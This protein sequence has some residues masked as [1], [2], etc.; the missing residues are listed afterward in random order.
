MELEQKEVELRSILE[1]IDRAILRAEYTPEG[2]L[3]FAN[4]LHRKTFGYN[5][6][7]VLGKSIFIFIPEE[8]QEEFKKLWAD[9]VAGNMRQLRVRRFTVTG[10]EVWLLNQYTPVIDPETGKVTKVLYLAQDI[11]EQVKA[12]LEAKKAL[13]IAKRHERHLLSFQEVLKKAEAERRAIL[14]GIDRAI[15]RAEYTPEGILTFANELHRKTFGYN[16]EEVL[17]KSIFIFIP[18]EEQEEFKKLW[19]DVVAGNMRQLR[20]RRF[21]AT[22]KEIWL[23]NQYTPVRDE[24]GN[25]YKILY[26]AQDITEQVRAEQE[27]KKALVEALRREKELIKLQREMEAAQKKMSGILR[28][29]DNMLYRIIYNRDGYIVDI[30]DNITK[31]FGE[32]EKIINKHYREICAPEDLEH[33]EQSFNKVLNGEIVK[34]ERQL[35]LGNRTV[36]FL[37]QFAPIYLEDQINEII[38]LNI[39]ITEQKMKEQQVNKL[40]QEALQRERDLQSLLKAVDSTMLRADYTP[41]GNLLD[42]NERH[43]QTMGY[44][45]NQMRGKNILE[46]IPDEEK[47]EFMEKI[48]KRVTSGES[49]QI[50]VKRERKDT[51]EE[52]W[53]LNQYTPVKDE[54]GNLERIIYLALDITEEKKL[55][56]KLSETI[57]EIMYLKKGVDSTLLR[58][59]YLPDGTLLDA[60]ALHQKTIGYNIEDFRGKNILEFVPE[61]ERD[62]FKKIWDKVVKGEPYTVAVYRERKDTGQP[63]WLLNHYVPVENEQGQVERIIY[64]AMD[65]TQQKEYEQRLFYLIQGVDNTLL[66]A[67]YLPDGTLL[68]ANELHQQII[69]YDINEFRGKNILEF[70]PPEQHQ[71]FMENI[72]N[73]VKKGEKLQVEVQR[74]RTDTGEVIWLL[75]SYV[76]VKDQYGKV[77]RIIYLAIDITRQKEIEQEL[78]Y[79]IRGI[80]RTQLRAEYAPDGTLLDANELHQ[81]ILGYKL[82]DYKGKNII[83]FVP[84]EGREEFYSYWK[85]V[86]VGEVYSIVVERERKDNGEIIWLYNQYI[87]VKDEYG[88]VERIIYLATDIT[89]L[90]KAEESLRYVLQGLDNI[91]LRAEYTPDGILLNANEMHQKVLGYKLEDYLGKSIFEFVPPEERE[92]FK[93][94]WEQVKSGQQYQITVRRERKD[95]GQSIWLMNHYIP[96]KDKYGKVRRIIYFAIDITLEKEL[97]QRLRYL[98]QGIDKTILRAEYN[99]DG[100]L[101]DANELHQKILGYKLV[102]F[103][104][105]HITEFVPPEER[106]NFM[107]I[108]NE[109]LQGKPHQ[110]VVRRERKDTGEDIWLL[111]QYIPI[112]DE[113]GKVVRVI[114]FAIDIT[115]QKQLEQRLYYLTLGIDQTL[116]RA[117]YEPDGTLL[118]A[119][120]LHQRIIGYD[121]SQMRGKNILEFVPEEEQEEFLKIWKQV[122]QGELKQ[123]VVRRERKDTGEEI[124][125]LNQYVP[126]KSAEGKVVRIIY[127]AVNITDY[128]KVYQEALQLKEEM[129]ALQVAIDATMLKAEYTPDGILLDANERHQQVMGYKL[130][131]M[132]GKSIFEFIPEEGREEF[133]RVW[134][135]VQ[136]GHPKQIV[137]R[138]KNMTTGEEIWL[139]NQYT[140]VFDKD[141]NVR[142]IL[143]LAIDITDRNFK[144]EIGKSG[145]NFDSDID[146]DINDWL[147][148]LAKG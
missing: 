36:W 67:E 41:E 132:K 24:S 101:L 30:S 34:F 105:K 38:V 71:E 49:V 92:E 50:T 124:W 3:T 99:A 119:N 142:K 144:P 5:Y 11:T 100:L 66:R 148:D 21:T 82:E 81:K 140:P 112:L 141:G 60:N 110:V 120:E 97:E 65:I 77:V 43:Q 69:G 111:N 6:E 104:G 86:Q 8:E 131:D 117:E 61:P 90:K 39:D 139:I 85:K 23:L 88:K 37:T 31:I 91:M 68:D 113:D 107:K 145:N 80:D 25:V 74:R 46:F 62:D 70:V 27:A 122:Q 13:E 106:E 44:D 146:K 127:L 17:G 84:E 7:E 59:E 147:D 20:V 123:V 134:K 143:Y 115:E 79:Y 75:N 133:E 128:Q 93:L 16:Y 103:I 53:L 51:G 125:L 109:V 55:E 89:E 40:L 14:A 10:E 96:V 98:M 22:G 95:T 108:W 114:Y 19:A 76:P 94:Y 56:E 48:W 130:E 129:E 126:V 118:D 26:L 29:I 9:V 72:W 116:L 2:I 45:I 63:I 138:R 73:R 78:K 137:V 102:D 33:F 15:L 28:A 12:E 58:A 121:I 87:P 42:A 32:R 18:E 47:Q 83:E 136:K 35:K 52:I 4:E 54:E 135:E 1:G 57:K 64:L